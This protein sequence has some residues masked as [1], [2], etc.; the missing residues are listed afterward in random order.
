M[1]FSADKSPYKTAIGATVGAGGYVRLSA[2]WLSAGRGMYTMT[3][4]ELERYRE[5][6]AAEPSGGRS[7]AG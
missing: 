4:D 1:R 3:P 2:A 6:V 5:A 7:R